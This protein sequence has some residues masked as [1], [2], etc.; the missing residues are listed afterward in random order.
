MAAS[1]A[2]SALATGRGAIRDSAHQRHVHPNLGRTP[3]GRPRRSPAAEAPPPRG[4]SVY[5]T[6][7][8]RFRR[9][10]GRDGDDRVLE[11]AAPSP[12]P[13]AVDNGVGRRH[14]ASMPSR[15]I[16]P[17]RDPPGHGLVAHPSTAGD[18]RVNAGREPQRWTSHRAR[19]PPAPAPGGAPGP[20]RETL[21]DRL[22]C[23]ATSSLLL[24]DRVRWTP[25]FRGGPVNRY[26]GC[27]PPLPAIKSSR[28]TPDAGT[29]RDV[30]GSTHPL[31]TRIARPE[32]AGT[33][34]FRYH[35]C[36]EGLLARGAR[37]AAVGPNRDA[38]HPIVT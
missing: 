1:A 2:R 15:P 17:T 25:C 34:P 6:A 10:R 38:R 21:G 30:I 7:V 28:P 22:P 29:D 14:R 35:E 37:S 12:R 24:T 11:R 33:L 18:R 19:P 3:Q 36:D 9:R 8:D 31:T 32:R 4:T 20:T 27:R 16:R 13:I 23:C 26:A 5:G